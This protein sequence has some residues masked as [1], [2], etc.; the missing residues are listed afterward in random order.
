MG[1]GGVCHLH[2][3]RKPGGIDMSFDVLSYAMG[4]SAKKPPTVTIVEGTTLNPLPGYSAVK[5]LDELSFFDTFLMIEVWFFT[6]TTLHFQLI[7]GSFNESSGR[8]ISSSVHE[9]SGTIQSIY[10]ITYKENDDRFELESAFSYDLAT[11]TI[12]PDSAVVQ[13]LPSKTYICRF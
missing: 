9:N 3:S 11:G 13:G 12:T 1:A 2:R 10:Y 7:P 5:L 8:I 6:E 4:R